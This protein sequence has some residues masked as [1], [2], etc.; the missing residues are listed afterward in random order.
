[1]L[2]AAVTAMAQA[3]LPADETVAAAPVIDG[4]REPSTSQPNKTSCTRE[5]LS[6]A[7]RVGGVDRADLRGF[8][9]A[10][11]SVRRPNDSYRNYR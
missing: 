5:S 4:G 9:A 10:G 6:G 8:P 11:S 7:L 1:M 3:Q 2:R